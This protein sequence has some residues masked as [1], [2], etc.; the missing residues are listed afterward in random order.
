MQDCYVQN[1]N[2][3]SNNYNPK[4]IDLMRTLQFRFNH[5]F[6]DFYLLSPCLFNILCH[7]GT[8][9]AINSKTRIQGPFLSSTNQSV[10]TLEPNQAKSNIEFRIQFFRSCIFSSNHNI[11]DFQDKITVASGY[12]IRYLCLDRVFTQHFSTLLLVEGAWWVNPKTDS[13]FLAC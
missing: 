9:I 2:F 12:V 3:Q 4:L 5:N 11:S 7:F 10:A 13:S 8:N 1:S 6:S